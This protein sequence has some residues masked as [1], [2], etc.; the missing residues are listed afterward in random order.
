MTLEALKH[1]FSLE[2][3]GY[4]EPR[5]YDENGFNQI[6]LTVDKAK[7]AGTV[8]F[9]LNA[10]Y[11][12]DFGKALLKIVSPNP[13]DLT[14]ATI[15]LGDFMHD[16]DLEGGDMFYLLETDGYDKISGN[17]ANATA[18]AKRNL[19]VEY[20]FIIDTEASDNNSLG[21]DRKLVARLAKAAP[22]PETKTLTESY[23]AGLVFLSHIGSWL[24]DY[25]YYTAELAIRQV[26]AWQA[27][28]GVDAS[29]F[30]AQT[31]SHVSVTGLTF[32]VGVAKKTQNADGSFLFGGFLEG[33]VS[34]YEV[35]TNVR[36]ADFQDVGGKGTIKSI[37]A[38]LMASQKFDNGFRVE[39]SVRYGFLQ[40][41]FTAENYVSA[42]GTQASYFITSPYFGAHFGLGYTH[43]LGENGNLDFS[44]KYYYSHLKG[45]TV[46]IG[47]G[48]NVEYEPTNSHRV[49]AGIRYTK[50]FSESVSFYFGSHYDYEFDNHARAKVYD[51][52]IKTVG[53]KGATGIFELGGT[54]KSSSNEHLS[55]E[56]GL[57]GYVGT[58]R[59]ISGGVRLGYEF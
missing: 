25:S 47:D 40:N 44:A 34:D 59:G 18:T 21:T 12:N 22:A 54:I 23:A 49:R 6:V 38:G 29:S 46:H 41:D 36:T 8:Y 35:V 20:T 24:P 27:F 16:A 52:E 7:L 37:G 11:L 45:Q 30:T 5:A 9:P 32:M 2:N 4:L 43:D 58:F 1:T 31:G 48:E 13:I 33:G 10:A 50:P 55:V 53:I 42:A 15:K 3:G 51:M 26:N 57:Q 28:S 14:G 17:A 56:F 39:T 19:A